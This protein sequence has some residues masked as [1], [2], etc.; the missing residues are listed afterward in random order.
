MAL[1]RRLGE[2]AGR[3]RRAQV[4][5]LLPPTSR[6]QGQPQASDE[7]VPL[8]QS[9]KPLYFVSYS[10]LPTRERFTEPHGYGSWRA[11]TANKRDRT[12]V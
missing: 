10:R 11:R 6:L 1:H 9:A 2:L 4:A 8:S 12:G 3:C 7:A 5:G